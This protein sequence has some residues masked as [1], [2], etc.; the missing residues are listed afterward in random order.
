MADTFNKKSLQQKK[1]KK[2]QD[3]LEKKAERK[4]NNDKGKDLDDMIVYLDEYG[5]LTDVH[6]DLQKK[7]KIKASDIQLGAAPILEEAY[8]G[9][10][11]LF[12]EDKGYGFITE[13]HS[14]NTVFV[15]INSFTEPLKEKDRVTYEK[16]K[17][18][19]GFAAIKV[20][21]IK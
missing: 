9:M 4:L 8:T 18:V 5:N 11:S 1:A 14:R 20:K 7:T 16:E 6:P 19:K 15:H 10:I 12:F 3:K 17:T 13:D 2:K 21:K